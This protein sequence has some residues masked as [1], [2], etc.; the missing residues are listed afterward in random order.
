MPTLEDFPAQGP[1]ALGDFQQRI[2][3]RLVDFALIQISMGM[4][5]ALWLLSQFGTPDAVP[6]DYE[7]P[8][9]LLAVAIAV[10]V[11]Y[12]TVLV[13][14]TGRTLGKLLFGLRVARYSDGKKPTISQAALRA[15]LPAAG[16]AVVVAA[17][18]LAGLGALPILASSF[19]NPLRRGWHDQA[20]GTLVVRTR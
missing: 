9:V 3:A 8:F 10:E 20:G 1:N 15:L 18:R 2:Y 19:F 17:T 16:G 11:V 13:A 4:I 5:F 12:E 7:T 14:L 6:T